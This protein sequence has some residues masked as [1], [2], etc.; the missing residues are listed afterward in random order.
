MIT[1]FYPPYSFGGD[2]VFVQQLSG[3]LARRGHHVEVVHCTD[4]YRLTAGRGPG[5]DEADDERVTVHRL[6]SRAGI[7]SPMLT[8]LS[9][10]PLLKTRRLQEILA[11]GFDVVHY[12]NMSLMGVPGPRLGAAGAVT[13]YT[14]HEYWLVCPTHMLF[15]Y[16]RAPCTRPRCVP[17]TLAHGR[18]PQ[19]WRGLG[20]LRR[21]AERIDVFIAASRFV[22]RKHE[23]MGFARPVAVLPHFTTHRPVSGPPPAWLSGT[24]PYFLFVGRLERVKGLHTL[25][26]IFRRYPRAR[27]LVA[28]TGSHEGTLRRM[29]ADAANIGF[30]GYQ[31]RDRLTQ[32]YARAVALI[33]PSLWYEVFGLVILEAFAQRTPAIVRNTGGMPE[34]I[35]HSGGG[36]AY[37]TDAQLL[38]T[39]DR[40]L[41]APDVRDSLGRRGHEALQR[42]WS[43]EA[44]IERYMLLIRQAA[45]RR[46]G[47]GAAAR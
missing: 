46:G 47:Q 5:P 24:A 25:I 18:P 13:L 45:D 36:V 29:A 14:L 34:I 44:H 27:L 41:D 22:R 37:D 26:P 38:A 35:E 11:R 9:G 10:L 12:H 42:R 28:G 32:L 6:H 31:P 1:T 39:M 43:P 4:A 16:D 17:C 21:A 30:L 15:K 3:E 33:V 40:L 8:H 19:L 20:L 7:V 2:A 23:E